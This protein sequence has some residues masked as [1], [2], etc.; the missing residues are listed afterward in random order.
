MSTHGDGFLIATNVATPIV[1]FKD[2]PSPSF[3]S[4]ATN[5]AM[6]T[7]TNSPTLESSIRRS[8]R[9]CIPSTH[10][11]GYFNVVETIEELVNV[12]ENGDEPQS[13]QEVA[14]DPHLFIPFSKYVAFPQPSLVFEQPIA[15]LFS[16]LSIT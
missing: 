4:I 5:F 12:M 1:D 8:R 14:K 15:N 10:L 9:V 6:H 13:F 7:T 3:D 16:P 2:V 11:Q